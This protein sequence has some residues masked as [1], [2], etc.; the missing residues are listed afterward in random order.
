LLALEDGDI[1]RARSASQ[2]ALAI[3]ERSGDANLEFR[4]LADAANVNLFDAASPEWLER[5]SHALDGSEPRDP[6]TEL[7][8]RYSAAQIS[9]ML[10]D[11]TA[12]TRFGFPMLALAERLRDR[13][14]LASA[15]RVRAYVH[16][17]LGDFATARRESDLSLSVAPE[18]PRDLVLRI[19]VEYE[20]GN[21]GQ[22]ERYLDRLIKL[23]EA[24]PSVANLEHL[25]AAL[26]VPFVAYLVRSP[27]LLAL[28]E[29]VAQIPSV[30][31]GSQRLTFYPRR[32]RAL[33]AIIRNDPS[34][35]QE[36]YAAVS[37]DQHPEVPFCT[38]CRDRLL[39][40]LA[41]T[42]GDE[43][44]AR[45]HFEAALSL[46]RSRGLRPELAWTSYNYAALLAR[47]TS[48]GDRARSA[49]LLNQALAISQEIGMRPLHERA[50][51]LSQ[52]T[53]MPAVTSPAYPDGLTEREVEVIRLV[54]AGKPDRIIADELSISVRTVSNHVS[55]ILGKTGTANRTEAATYA[56][57]H[58]LVATKAIR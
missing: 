2:R 26:V 56:L 14:W 16:W 9:F 50:L 13:F 23:M 51:A 10:G 1:P 35:A 41:E 30:T 27:R 19:Q 22:G 43:A 21:F 47:A 58:G 46:C 12:I 34:L 48:H 53:P 8:A 6:Q 15:H 31:I 4:V 57:R 38:L 33:A 20:A 11:T 18:E 55:S 28:A 3:A 45:Q 42:F 49:D 39:G 44:R 5:I 40:L 54:A 7:V 24:G 52:R 32:G 37:R 36:G 29:Q 17:L 25:L